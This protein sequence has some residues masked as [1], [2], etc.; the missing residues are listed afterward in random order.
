M[1]DLLIQQLKQDLIQKSKVLETEIKDL[2]QS[3]DGE[4]KSSAG[5]KYETSREM[6]NSELEKNSNA[7]D[8][9]LNQIKKLQ[10]LEQNKTIAKSVQMGSIVSCEPSSSFFIFDAI[11]KYSFNGIDYFI[12]SPLAPIAKELLNKKEGDAIIFNQN[13]IIIKQIS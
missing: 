2:I 13:K 7:L 11:G 9:I 4:Q 5:D 8:R 1:K 10:H 3:R 12:I 6:I